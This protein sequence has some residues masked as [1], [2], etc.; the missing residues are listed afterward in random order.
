MIGDMLTCEV[1][2][3]NIHD[4]YAVA[5]I[6]LSGNIVGHVPRHISTVCHLFI[7]RTGTIV[8][9]V[10]GRKR[11]SSDLTQG[12]FEIPCTYTFSG[13]DET[14]MIKTQRLIEKVSIVDPSAPPC[15]PPN[16]KKPKVDLS[17]DTSDSGT[18]P[19]EQTW[20]KIPGCFI[21]LSDKA[22]LVNL[23]KLNDRHINFSQRLLL[24]QFPDTEGLVCTLFQSKVQ[25]AKRIKFGVQVIHD[26]HR[27]H[28]LLASNMNCVGT[29]EIHIYDS[30]YTSVDE[31]TKAIIKNLLNLFDITENPVYTL[32]A[33]QKQVGGSDCGLFAIAAV[34]TL[35]FKKNVS[36]VTYCQ[37]K[38]RQHL[39]SCFESKELSLFP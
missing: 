5:V 20:M 38:M 21:T 10:T 6:V 7:R 15:E 9:Q 17:D 33:M 13:T 4:I 12:G 37:I 11:H 29:N 31:R 19:G 18:D 2:H 14:R 32:I 3:G 8:C 28:W 35:L 34:T 39:L 27:Q 36:N 25:Q 23:E 16:S 24:N 1:E 26:Q 30:M 22:T